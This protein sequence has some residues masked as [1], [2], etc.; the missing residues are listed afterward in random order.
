MFCCALARS[1]WR[2]TDRRMELAI[3]ALRRLPYALYLRTGHWERV[4]T[5]ALERARHQC[6][7]CP[8]AER[9]E[10]HHRTYVRLGFEAPSDLIV[11]CD[12][13]H[14]HHH[15]RARLQAVRAMDQPPAKAPLVTAAQI[16]W[17]TSA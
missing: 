10:V 11:L 8:S 7:L 16:R 2:Q 9:L 12:Q 13:C 3:A 1:G 4:R 14:R 15:R 17:K 6:A 5:F